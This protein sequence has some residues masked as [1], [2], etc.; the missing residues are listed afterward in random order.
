MNKWKIENNHKHC[1][2]AKLNSTIKG[3][4]YQALKLGTIYNLYISS[5]NALKKVSNRPLKEE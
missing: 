2:D 3:S 1:H 4:R 5:F